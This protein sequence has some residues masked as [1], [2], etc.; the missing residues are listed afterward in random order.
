MQ[1]LTIIKPD[2]WHTHLR[3]AEALK[4][5]VPHTAKQFARAVVMPN[6]TPPIVNIQ[7]A[8]DYKNAIINHIPQ[9]CNFIP[10]M[11]L[12]L[13][14]NTDKEIIKSASISKDID[15]IG[16]KLYPAGATTN[17]DFGV[18][19]IKKIYP[20]LEAMEKH[21]LPLL[22]HGE[23]T[24]HDI[25][26]FDREMVFIDKFLVNIRKTFPHLKIILEHI[27]TKHAVQFIMEH[28]AGKKTAATITPHHLFL[29]RN[30]LLVGG[31]KP[32]YYCLPILKDRNNQA[33]IITAALSDEP[34]FF[35]GSDSAPHAKMTKRSACGCAGIYHGANTLLF[36]A[37]FFDDNNQLDKL[38]AF[39]SF[40]GADFYDLPRNIETITLKKVTHRVPNEYAYLDSMIIPFWCGKD[41]NWDF[42]S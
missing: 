36:Y 16:C 38:E 7:Q 25:D 18:S 14:D 30:D 40:Y 24:D 12:Y 6:L 19:N 1:S 31:I 28:Q 9:G 41:L 3:Q 5:T 39:V 15:I 23:V 13:T 27:T 32:D 22:V 34:C 35:A 42:E 4:T 37:Q 20:T 8:I 33:A 11:T 2:D 10:L 26:I 29:N 17:S 21:E